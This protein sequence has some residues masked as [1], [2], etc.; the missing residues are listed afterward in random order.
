[1][2]LPL[3]AAASPDLTEP[4]LDDPDRAE[5]SGRL[6]NITV[7]AVDDDPD[8]LQLLEETLTAAGGHVLC[9]S[10]ASAALR[11]LDLRLPQVI[12]S[13]IGMPDRDG[14]DLIAAVRR[15]SRDKGGSIPAAALTAYV[16]PGDRQRVL[17]AGFQMHLGKPVDP[18]ELVSAVETLSSPQPAQ[19]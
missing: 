15:R 5:L 14:F 13:D 4:D 3:A 16:R 1:V 6:A 10:S 11:L 19:G 9:A 12:I 18:D 7:L 2:R 17:D 8:S